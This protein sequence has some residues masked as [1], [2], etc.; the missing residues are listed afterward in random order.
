M[1]TQGEARR[2]GPALVADEPVVTFTEMVRSLTAAACSHP[3]DFEEKHRLESE[4]ALMLGVRLVR[5]VDGVV[6][7]PEMYDRLSRRAAEERRHA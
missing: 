7:T 4:A 1:S 2:F 3:V 5:D 6:T